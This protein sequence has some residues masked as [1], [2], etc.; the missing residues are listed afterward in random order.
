MVM[1]L[2]RQSDARPA[3]AQKVLIVEDTADL[4]AAMD[5]I[6]TEAGYGTCTAGRGDEALK[7]FYSFQPDLVLLDLALPGVK[8][9][10]VCQA[11]R[12]LST[13]PI[14]IFSAFGD[15]AEK[16]KAFERGADDYV[17][18]G[19]DMRELV[20][21]IGVALRRTSTSREEA[22]DTY[23]DAQVHIDH[24]RRLVHVRGEAVELTRTEYELLVALIQ[25]AQP[26][27]AHQ[28]LRSVWGPKYNSDELVK[29]HIGRLRKKIEEN[30]DDPQLVVTRRGFGYEYRRPRGELISPGF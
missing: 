14:I 24:T 30:Q 13:V 29:W 23:S 28:L 19:T 4:R 17:V 3:I 16:L 7:A 2:E 6:L 1:M 18:K 11:I 5:V 9:M 21:R 8:G 12:Q 25:S 22:S 20:A 27:P 15:V 26:M 10:D